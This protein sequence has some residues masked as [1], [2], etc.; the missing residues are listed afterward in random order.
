[1]RIKSLTGI[2]DRGATVSWTTLREEKSGW[3][4]EPS[5]SLEAAT[6]SA[7]DRAAAMLPAF[8]K[9][10]GEI[11]L[12]LPSTDLLLRV[13]D[14]PTSI[15]EEISGMVALQLDKISPFPIDQ[16]RSAWEILATSDSGCRVLVAAIPA[17]RIESFFQPFQEAGVIPTRLDARILGWWECLRLSGEIPEQGF[18][19]GL[20]VDSQSAELI[21]AQ[22]GIP[23]IFVSLGSTR[24]GDPDTI[25]RMVTE[26]AV[27]ALESLEMEEAQQLPIRVWI[28]GGALQQT[29][30]AHLNTI[31]N[32]EVDLRPTN[33]LQDLSEGIARRATR[34]TGL[35]LLPVEWREAATRH[36][37]RRRF[38]VATLGL[39][40]VFSAVLILGLTLFSIQQRRTTALKLRLA[41]L[42][43]PAKEMRA[44]QSR[45]AALEQY[46][47]PKG[48]VLEIL[49]EVVVLLPKGIDLTSFSCRKGSTLSFR[50][51]AAAPDPVYD[52]IQALQRSDFFTEVNPAPVQT[53]AD[54]GLMPVQF[55]I[56][57]TLPG[58]AEHE[59]EQP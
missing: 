18:L 3:T 29:L 6:D 16:M 39:L 25:A 5:Q 45:L 33:A 42:E 44:L 50:G 12:A 52:F 36:R 30:P 49:R 20:I 40:G 9:L 17:D 53:R 14:L 24:Q 58:N 15:S 26:E 59:T 21:V 55:S 38:M 19:A 1:M 48:S 34:E 43:E 22:E 10:S 35:N 4:A 57:C 37:A 51:Q 2:I 32:R 13:L 11:A 8:R 41:Q 56:T 7:A 46:S 47:N 28:L 54:A 31:P 27:F 23:L